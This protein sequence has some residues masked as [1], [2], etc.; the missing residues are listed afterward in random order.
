MFDRAPR[1][2]IVMLQ[3]HHIKLGRSEGSCA[4]P[5]SG[6]SRNGLT[7]GGILHLVGTA[8]RHIVVAYTWLKTARGRGEYPFW[9]GIR[10]WHCRSSFRFHCKAA[11]CVPDWKISIVLVSLLWFIE[12]LYLKSSYKCPLS[13]GWSYSFWNLNFLNCRPEVGKKDEQNFE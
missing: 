13:K 9:C 6:I 10:R 3:R 12:Q 2:L 1:P 11:F 8:K 5:F 4:T 7:G